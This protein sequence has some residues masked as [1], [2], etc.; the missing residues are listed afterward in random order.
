MLLDEKGAAEYVGLSVRM[1]EN[2]RSR[3]EGPDYFQ[4][5]KRLIRY[6]PASLD[7]WLEAARVRPQSAA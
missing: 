4:F 3:G 5:N 6:T 7:A 2:A 1:L